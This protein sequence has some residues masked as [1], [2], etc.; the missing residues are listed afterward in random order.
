[1]TDEATGLVYM[2]QPSGGLAH[3]IP[4]PN[5]LGEG[6]SSLLKYESEKFPRGLRQGQKRVLV[7]KPPSPDHWN[8]ALDLVLPLALEECR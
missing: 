5:F 1:M 3:K 6:T 8:M 2:V 7:L 4:F